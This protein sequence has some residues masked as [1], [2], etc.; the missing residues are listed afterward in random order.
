MARV[1]SAI[2]DALLEKCKITLK[3]QGKT[4]EIARRLQAIISAKRHNI[5]KV[6][7]VFGVTRVTMMRWI[8]DFNKE[9]IDGLVVRKG[10]GRK[11]IFNKNDEDKIY[12][13]IKN[14]PNITAKEL[15]KVIESDLLKT[16]GIAT[17]YRLMR[18]LGFSYITPRPTHYKQDKKQA[19]DFKKKSSK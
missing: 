4:G 5:S 14:N 3:K 2:S 19:D 1:S 8:K 17:V 15:K 10:R 7:S 9:S 11:R 16:V 18:D 13:I 6:A 12:K